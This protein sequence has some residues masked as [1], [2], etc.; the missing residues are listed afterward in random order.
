M[1]QSNPLSPFFSLSPYPSQTPF[2][3]TFYGWKLCSI[4]IDISDLNF[5]SWSSGCC[6]RGNWWQVFVSVLSEKI[7]F[8]FAFRND[9]LIRRILI[10]NIS[11]N[12]SILIAFEIVRPV[13]LVFFFSSHSYHSQ[14]YS[15]RWGQTT[16]SFDSI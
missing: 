8:S 3:S 12:Y 4:V 9:S 2:P 6:M 10:I 1:E 7:Y 13:S 15:I 5:S 11:D 14:S 16:I